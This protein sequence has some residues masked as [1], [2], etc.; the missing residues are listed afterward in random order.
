VDQEGLWTKVQGRDGGGTL[1]RISSAGDGSYAFLRAEQ[2]PGGPKVFTVAGP[3]GD[4]SQPGRYAIGELPSDWEIEDWEIEDWQEPGRPSGTGSPSH[5]G[6]GHGL[7]EHEPVQPRAPAGDDR[8]LDEDGAEQPGASGEAG[9]GGEAVADPVLSAAAEATRLETPNPGYANREPGR[10]L[11]S[12]QVPARDDGEMASW[13]SDLE[14]DADWI[15]SRLP[16]WLDKHRRRLVPLEP[17]LGDIFGALQA[18]GPSSPRR[19][20]SGLVPASWRPG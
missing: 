17:G 20:A 1:A 10:A 14:R 18:A 11:E 5:G 9:G 7:A 2:P 4:G 15:A 3:Q 12:I 6:P 13:L 19:G 8:D 16:S